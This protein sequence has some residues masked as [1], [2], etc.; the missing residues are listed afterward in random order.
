MERVCFLLYCDV[1]GV[2]HEARNQAQRMIYAC[3]EHFG[4]D[5][6]EA[7]WCVESDNTGNAVNVARC[8]GMAEA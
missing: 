1:L 2:A 8:L 3:R 6:S 5:V 4:V 7:F